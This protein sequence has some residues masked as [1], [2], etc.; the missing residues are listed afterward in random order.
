MQTFER[1]AG[2]PKCATM[3]RIEGESARKGDAEPETAGFTAPRV[4][5]AGTP[6]AIA[7][8]HCAGS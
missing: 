3:S 8:A 2:L 4:A 5:A 6:S 1:L 7:T